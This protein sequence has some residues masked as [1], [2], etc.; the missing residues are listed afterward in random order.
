MTLTITRPEDVHPE[1][2]TYSHIATLDLSKVSKLIF[3]AGQVPV[4]PDGT[5]AGGEDEFRAQYDQVFQNLERTL[6]AAGATFANVA[7]T[8]T[9]LT[10][11]KHL[12]ELRALRLETYP[13]IFG[14][15]EYPPN[16][17]LVVDA[18]YH[19]DVFLEIEA[20]VAI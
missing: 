16:T 10:R 8:R 4:R 20:V 7:S 12:D 2:G 1:V 18:L 15:G 9:F 6:R 19:P 17:L 5:V 14:G 11:E 3:L 13:E